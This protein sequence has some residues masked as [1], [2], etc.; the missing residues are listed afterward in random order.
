[1][2]RN[3]W[4]KDGVCIPLLVAAGV[5]IYAGHMVAINETGFAVPANSGADGDSLAVI[6]VAEERIDNS[7][8][9]DG[10][11]TILVHRGCAFFLVNSTANPV[12]QVLIRRACKVEDSVTVCADDTLPR[13]AGTV[14]EVSP[15]GV[16]VFIS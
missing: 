2:D 8:G 4:R 12:T 5:V 16:W 1:M 13:T 14:I 3:T 9:S 10:A 15:D 6:G 11:Q 7:N